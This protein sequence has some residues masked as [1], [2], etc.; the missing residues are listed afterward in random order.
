MRFLLLLAFSAALLSLPAQA[1]DAAAAPPPAD[2]ASGFANID[3]DDAFNGKL[4]VLRANSDR[5]DN[6]LLS[7]SATLKNVTNRT[8][9]AEVGTCY[10]DATGTWLNGGHAGWLTFKLKP[11]MQFEYRSASMSDAASAYLVRIRTAE[12]AGRMVGAAAR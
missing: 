9:L 1:D 2:N 3:L 11:H 8:I 5:S 6:N 7:V 12:P 10:A 4:V